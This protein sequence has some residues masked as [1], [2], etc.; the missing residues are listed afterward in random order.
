MYHANLVDDTITS[1]A[2]KNVLPHMEMR[3]EICNKSYA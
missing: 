1:D 3:L 2:L